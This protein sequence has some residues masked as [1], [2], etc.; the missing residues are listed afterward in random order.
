[1]LLPA[2]EGGGGVVAAIGRFYGTFGAQ[3]FGTI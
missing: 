3:R 1:L 2:R